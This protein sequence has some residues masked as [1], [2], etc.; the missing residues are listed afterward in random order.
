MEFYRRLCGIAIPIAL[1][2][3]ITVGVNMTDTM[4]MGTLGEIGL[5]ATALANQFI[6][7]YQI[8]CM[9][10]GMG[11]SV[12]VARFWGMKNIQSLK[13]TITITFRFCVILALIFTIVTIVMPETLIR[14]YTPDQDIIREGSRYY[15]WSI[16]TYLLMGLSLVCTIILRSVGKSKIP[17][18][19]SIASFISNI[20]FNWVFIFGRL[21]A[22]R[23]EVA[24][25]AL[26]TVIARV[27]EF[28]TILCYFLLIDKTIRYKLKDLLMD[29]NDLVKEYINISLPVLVSDAL[30]ALGMSAIAMIMGRI[31]SSFVSANSITTVTQRL[32]TVLTQ[33][34][35]QAGCIITGHTLGAGKREQAQREGYYLL[36][37]GIIIGIV[38]GFIILIIS[39][40]VI[41][42]YNITDETK[43]I[44]YQLMNAV[45]FIVVFQSSNTILTKGVLRGGGDTKF[46]ML[47][48]IIFLWVA[49]IPLGILAGLVFHMSAFWI[50]FFM[51][52]DQIIKCIWCV[53]RLRSG[54]WIKI[55]GS[56][57]EE[58][59]LG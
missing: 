46:L 35:C 11:A 19:C 17:L 53:F 44:A 6:G 55:F 59:S 25:A 31:G 48:D 16:P 13:K 40:P 32:T 7:I 45:A 30:L 38:A 39:K 15:R 8:C 27:L 43:K 4:M 23:M 47:A 10:L 14:I 18:I 42:C 51:K 58:Q 33:G 37:F 26:G 50:Y 12:M 20:F 57:K 56:S 9:G 1:Q 5:S 52:I 34:I 2:S 28:V 36:Y 21:G 3:L 41:E 22:P 49:S 54:K 29:C 24:G